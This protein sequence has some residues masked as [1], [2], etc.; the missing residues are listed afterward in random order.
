[1]DDGVGV[2]EVR[3]VVAD[4]DCRAESGEFTQCP[5]VCAV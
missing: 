4:V 3:G 1:M 2:A 5:A